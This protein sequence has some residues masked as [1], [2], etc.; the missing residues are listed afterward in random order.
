MAK[1]LRSHD[2]LL[3]HFEQCPLH[4]QHA[5]LCSGRRK[6]GL[7]CF[8]PAR[9]TE[10]TD[11][12]PMCGR[13]RNQF[14]KAGRCVAVLAC[15]FRCGRL[16]KWKPPEFQLCP[17]HISYPMPCFFMKIPTELRQH[18]YSYL[19]PDQ[20]IP[21]LF[22]QRT[23]LRSDGA[24]VQTSILCTSRQIYEEASIVLYGRV[25]FSIGITPRSV[26]MCNHK[27]D[28]FETS[29][30]LLQTEEQTEEF[31]SRLHSPVALQNTFKENIFPIGDSNFGKI[32]SFHVEILLP[33][34]HDHNSV[35][36]VCDFV[37]K[38]VG[39]FEK[40]QRHAY[41]L[42]ILV[43]LNYQDKGDE[44]HLICVLTVAYFLLRPF[45]RLRNVSNPQIHLTTR[46]YRISATKVI[47]SDSTYPK[48]RPLLWFQKKLKYLEEEIS[49][50]RPV[51]ECSGIEAAYMKLE[52]L[53]C[54][55]RLPFMSPFHKSHDILDTLIR[56]ARVARE[57][58]DL[59]EF[60][61]V[62]DEVVKIWSDYLDKHARIRERISGGIDCIYG[63]IDKLPER[64]LDTAQSTNDNIRN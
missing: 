47:V 27:G 62:C 46:S 15:G 36:T 34:L 64:T 57:M 58:N 55:F 54:I 53:V 49:S 22:D 41:N 59:P 18:I 50:T 16:F 33:S 10:S 48:I 4:S 13:H 38:V 44:R 14:C 6:D 23:Q 3:E 19:L 42:E 51:P 56:R 43:K 11:S 32:R 29:R 30:N 52:S 45:L 1:R 39:Q 26:N 40:V 61:K 31:L 5:I 24:K 60:R 28:L 25:P 2:T 21:A 20:H 63:M 17:N 8:N 9:Y 37:R 12:M 35:Y 7:R